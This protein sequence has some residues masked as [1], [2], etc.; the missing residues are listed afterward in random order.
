MFR[1]LSIA[2]KTFQKGEVILRQGEYVEYLWLLESGTCYRHMNTDK[3]DAIIYSIKH[4]GKTVS[5][6]LGVLN[7]YN[8]DQIS[9]FSFVARTPCKCLCIPADAFRTWVDDKP[10]VLK[11]LLIL[12]SNNSTEL[13][14]AFR[15]FQEGR[16][17]NRLC[18]ILLSCSKTASGK[19]MIT[20][21]YTFTEIASMLGIHHVTVSRI[22]RALC[23]EGV[24]KKDTGCIL[25]LNR[26][27]LT[28]YANNEIPLSYK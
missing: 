24:L 13:R 22:I 17:A 6:L 8:C 1:H 26:E 15:A 2:T 28:Q 25:I 4:P 9:S 21:D 27:R 12:S 23:E 5:S 18:K 7:L 20:K 3:G 10:A 16:V 14:I 19:D 11:D